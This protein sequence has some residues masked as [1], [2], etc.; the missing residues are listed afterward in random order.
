MVDTDVFDR[1]SDTV[2]MESDARSDIMIDS[3]K[4]AEKRDI[5]NI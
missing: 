2:T 1:E 4:F 3:V 5:L